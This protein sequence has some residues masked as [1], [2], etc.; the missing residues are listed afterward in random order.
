M[1]NKKESKK[2]TNEKSDP[3]TNDNVKY[4]GP[5]FWRYLLLDLFEHCFLWEH[6]F[7]EDIRLSND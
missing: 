6:K 7:Y 2:A 3:A 5:M 1:S 4:R